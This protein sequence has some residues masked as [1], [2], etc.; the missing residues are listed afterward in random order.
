MA[1]TESEYDRI[2]AY[3]EGTLS[4][5]EQRQLEA[6]LAADPDLQ[7]AVDEHRVI[8]EGLQVPVAVEYFQEMHGQLEE[9]GLLEFDE[10]WVEAIDAEQH[11]SPDH[12]AHPHS[13]HDEPE[14]F[15]TSDPKTGPD[16][17]TSHIEVAVHDEP[18]TPHSHPDHQPDDWDTPLDSDSPDP[19]YN[20]PEE[21]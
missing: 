7:Q 8:W 14:V 10:L 15:V 11:T 13:D 3:L 9:Q 18:E 19:H 16:D 20:D 1:L 6:E 21:Y 2:E 17:T 5:D 4:P 12:S